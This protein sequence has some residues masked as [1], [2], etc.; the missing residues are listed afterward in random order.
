MKNKKEKSYDAVKKM[1][2]IRE[3]LSKEY[4]ENFE[5]EKKDLRKIQSKYRIKPLRNEL[6]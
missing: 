3:S 4:F 6:T 2:E 1:R 5:K